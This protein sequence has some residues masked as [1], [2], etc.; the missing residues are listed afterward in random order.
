M[1]KQAVKDIQELIEYLLKIRERELE[2]NEENNYII[3]S[4]P[5]NEY[6]LQKENTKTMQRFEERLITLNNLLKKEERNNEVLEIE[7]IQARKF[8]SP[9]QLAEL[10]TDM[11]LS[12]Q[13]TYR[14]RIHDPLPHR[15]KAPRKKIT[16]I[17]EEVEIWMENNNK[18]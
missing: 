17:A 1:N 14:G 18:H 6:D 7:K 13:V 12:S 16:Y 11:S 8:L 3:N 5:G 4:F 15:Q 10:Y 9:K 2:Q